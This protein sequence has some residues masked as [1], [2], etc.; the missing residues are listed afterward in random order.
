MHGTK[1]QFRAQV[2]E[3]ECPQGYCNG[4]VSGCVSGTADC[5]MPH[6]QVNIGLPYQ[7]GIPPI[8]RWWVGKRQNFVCT[9]SPQLNSQNQHHERSY[10]TK[11]WMTRGGESIEYKWLQEKKWKGE[12]GKGRKIRSDVE[13]HGKLGTIVWRLRAERYWCNWFCFC[14]SSRNGLVPCKITYL[15]GTRYTVPVSRILVEFLVV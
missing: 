3:S 14:G 2:G 12:F 10:D 6:V 13:S 5:S 1:S 4:R 8:L 9:C 15:E 7:F 11:W